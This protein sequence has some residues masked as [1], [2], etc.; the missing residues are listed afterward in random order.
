MIGGVAEVQLDADIKLKKPVP[1]L[2]RAL[3]FVEPDGGL[4]KDDPRQR[5]MDLFK[6][7]DVDG[8]KQ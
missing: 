4:T 1:A 5:E 2:G 3:F 6:T 7:E 8:R